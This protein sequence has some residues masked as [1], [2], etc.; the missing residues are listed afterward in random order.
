MKF[1]S[2]LYGRCTLTK[3]QVK[4]YYVNGKELKSVMSH[5]Q[6]EGT[7]FLAGSNSIY[8]PRGKVKYIDK[9]VCKPW[10]DLENVNTLM[11]PGEACRTELS[12]EWPELKRVGWS[13]KQ[14]VLF[15]WRSPLHYTGPRVGPMIYIDLDAAYSQIYEKLWLDTTYPRAYHGRY[16]LSDVAKRLKVWKAARN[17]L[18][19][20]TRSRDGVAYKGTKRIA[21][22]MRNK[23]LSPGL[24]AT[25]QA[26]LH[27]IASRAIDLGAIYVN[28]DGYLFSL[29]DDW[30]EGEFLLWL[31]DLGFRW[32]IRDQGAGEIVSWNNYHVGSTRT[33]A[34]RLGLIQNSREFSNV[35]HSNGRKWERF[36]EGCRRIHGNS[37]GLEVE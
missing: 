7:Y 2:K 34:N 19:G 30:I 29:G 31:S 9:S 3:T 11:A 13:G 37:V 15:D 21:I 23:Y 10:P 26:I 1:L 24:W 18:I 28:V 20:I 4:R 17:S 16:P 8:I 25:V 27:M 5:L 32:S 35:N 6:R 22:K 36:W 14:V 12:R 33:Q